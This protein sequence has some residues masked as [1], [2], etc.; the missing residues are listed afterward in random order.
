MSIEINV[1]QVS[2]VMLADGWHSISPGSFEVDRAEFSGPVAGEAAPL[3]DLWFRFEES[4]S[5]IM[6]TGPLSSVVA[7]RYDEP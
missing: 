6:T 1:D 3:R 2:E 5:E 4:S 7:V